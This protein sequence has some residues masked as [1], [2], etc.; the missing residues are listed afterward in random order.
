MHDIGRGNGY[1]RHA[2]LHDALQEAVVVGD[3]ALLAPELLLGIGRCGDAENAALGA[4]AERAVAQP[5]ARHRID[6]ARGPAAAA[7]LAVGDARQRERLLEGD[8]L[9]NA[10]V[11]HGAESS[12]V[13]L[14][15]LVRARRF[16]ETRRSHEAADVLGVEGRGFHAVAPPR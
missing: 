8:D 2:A 4:E 6:E 13:E 7:K 9:A 15:G 16:D 5:E 14:A 3:D 1:L 12:L 10:V 11:L